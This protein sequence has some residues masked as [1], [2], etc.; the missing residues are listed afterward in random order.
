[1]EEM[2]RTID[3]KERKDEK[4]TRHEKE[5][6]IEKLVEC[7]QNVEI[8]ECVE[9]RIQEAYRKIYEGPADKERGI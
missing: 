2:N 4:M 8:P 6:K 3:F 5:Q 7:Y 9:A 1:M